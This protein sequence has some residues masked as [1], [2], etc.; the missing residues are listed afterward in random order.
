[1]QREKEKTKTK[2]TDTNKKQ[3]SYTEQTVGNIKTKN[4]QIRQVQKQ[5]VKTDIR[6]NVTGKVSG[7]QNKN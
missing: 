2:H 1:M 6:R 3:K 5:R 4:K 7:D